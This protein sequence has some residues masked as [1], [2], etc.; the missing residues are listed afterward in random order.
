ME[1]LSPVCRTVADQRSSVTA[2]ACCSGSSRA[3][4]LRWDP[5][6]NQQPRSAQATSL[7]SA[8]GSRK[9][10]GGVR[11]NNSHARTYSTR[12]HTP[13]D[14]RFSR[15]QQAILLCDAVTAAE[16]C[17]GVHTPSPFFAEVREMVSVVPLTLSSTFVSAADESRALAFA[18]LAG[19]STTIG[20]VV[21]VRKLSKRC[22]LPS[23]TI[24][25]RCV[26]AHF[27]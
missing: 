9:C 7:R 6:N 5:T 21:S 4:S 12:L 14:R 15:R 20:G 16:Q 2:A 3:Q 1:T 27:S 23:L 17:S 25:G 19:L 26:T 11:W 13:P 18:T 10:E 8:A 22:N 24:T